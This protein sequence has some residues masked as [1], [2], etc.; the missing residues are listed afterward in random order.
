[1]IAKRSELIE[2]MISVPSLIGDNITSLKHGNEA[3][4]DYMLD[5]VFVGSK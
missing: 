4:L 3:F 5:S 2:G 1:M